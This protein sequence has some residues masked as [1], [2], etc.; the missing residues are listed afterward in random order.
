MI[1]E[2]QLLIAEPQL[3]ITGLTGSGGGRHFLRR[4]PS[5]PA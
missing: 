3:L 4:L 2:P 5:F 1:A